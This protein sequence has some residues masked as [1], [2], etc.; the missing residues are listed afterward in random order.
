M[1]YKNSD[2][3]VNVMSKEE[4]NLSAKIG[5][6]EKE[7]KEKSYYVEFLEDKFIRSEKEMETMRR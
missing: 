5:R 4:A 3:L 1:L 2:H 7:M 6:L